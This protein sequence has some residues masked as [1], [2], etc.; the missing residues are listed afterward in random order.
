MA[1]LA[2]VGVS[3]PVVFTLTNSSY[4]S[5]TGETIPITINAI[6]GTNTDNT[7]TFK[8]SGITTISGSSATSI[9]KLNSASFIIFDGSKDGTSSRDLTITNTSTA[10]TTAAIWVASTGTGGGSTNDTIKNCNISAGNSTSGAT[11]GVALSGTTIGSAGA[12]NDTVTIQNNGITSATISIYANGTA[13]VSTGGLDTLMITGNTVDSNS[14]LQNYGIEVGNALNSTINQNTVSVTS[15]GAFQPT[16]ISLETGF[17]TSRVSRNL[18]TSAL[19]SATGGYGGRGITIGT[20]TATSALTIS[21][22]VIYGVNGSN[23]SSFSNSSSMGIGIGM[24]GGSTTLTTTTGG[25]GLYFNSVSM[26]GSMGSGSTTATTAAMYVGSGASALDVRDNVFANTQLGTGPT[27]KNYAIYSA[28][29]NTAFTMMD[30]NVYFVSNTFNAASAIPGFIG[31]DRS[32]LNAIQAGFGQNGS[33]LV[34]DPQFNGTTNLQPQ[35]GSPGPGYWHVSLG[36]S[37]ALQ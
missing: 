36:F 3:G 16:G 30:Y 20:G 15:S 5:S 4:N 8:P 26:S 32:N 18:I 10:A 17:V 24:I 13:S 33:S 6:S 27:Q 14:A 12:D 22:N 19:T 25:I 23:Y 31:S 28:A 11:Y 1:D 7:V 29:A 35:L 34:V 9:I 2:A 21:N 37:H